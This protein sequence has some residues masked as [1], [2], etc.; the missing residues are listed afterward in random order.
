M[1]GYCG[2][3]SIPS[4]VFHLVTHSRLLHRFRSQKSDPH[5]NTYKL[6]INSVIINTCLR[7]SSQSVSAVDTS[8][9]SV[10][11]FEHS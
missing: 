2:T 6:N 1:C 4:C 10:L 11:W 5:I 8:A 3:K 9:F 7:I